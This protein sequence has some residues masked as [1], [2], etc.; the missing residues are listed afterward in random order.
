M[1][2]SARTISAPLHRLVGAD[3]HVEVRC[4]LEY[5]LGGVYPAL[6]AEVLALALGDDGDGRVGSDDL[7]EAGSGRV[8]DGQ[9]P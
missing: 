8:I 7:V 1:P 3:E 2:S 5:V 4:D 6:R 9:A